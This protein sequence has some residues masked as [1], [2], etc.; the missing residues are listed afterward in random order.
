MLLTA[1]ADPAERYIDLGARKLERRR[2]ASRARRWVFSR[3]AMA[4]YSVGIDIGGTFSDCFVTDGSEGW[5]G[6]APTTPARPVDGLF[7]SLEN[8]AASIGRPLSEIL[9]S[10]VH[11]GLGTTVVT[12]CLAQLAGAPTGLLVTE[13]FGD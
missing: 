6:K 5:R 10:T 1:S 3:T 7:A 8:A 11:F 12:N 4:A 9:S 2:L 13:G